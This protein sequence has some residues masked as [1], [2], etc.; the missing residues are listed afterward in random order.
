VGFRAERKRLHDELQA[1]EEILA[2]DPLALIEERPELDVLAHPV[3]VVTTRS[4]FVILSGTFQGV[5]RIDFDHIAAV[6]RR[7]DRKL[8]NTLRLTMA[9]GDVLTCV[10]EP[11]VQNQATA[12]LITERFF[13]RIIKDTVQERVPPEE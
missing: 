3:F 1:D 7:L 4:V 12:D 13:G 11:R 2:S 9:D 10:Y 6:E 8:G 5:R